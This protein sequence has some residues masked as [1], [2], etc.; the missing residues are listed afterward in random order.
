MKKFV[1]QLGKDNAVCNNVE[2]A[3]KFISR[4]GHL[5]SAGEK[6]IKGLFDGTI[7]VTRD[8]AWMMPKHIPE[9]ILYPEQSCRMWVKPI[10]IL[11]ENGYS[12]EQSIGGSWR[13]MR[14]DVLIYDDP[15]CEDLNE[16]E[17]T[18]VAFFTGYFKEYVKSYS[19]DYENYHVNITEDSEYYHIDFRTGLGEAHYLKSD[20]TLEEALKD[21]AEM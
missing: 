7:K 18:A 14:D 12:L 2:E 11:E 1:L 6:R 4:F 8:F 15:A 19:M 3:K 10:S 21:Q 9:L 16:D 13:L 17:A 5:T 20:W